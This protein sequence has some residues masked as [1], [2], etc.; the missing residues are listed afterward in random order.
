MSIEMTDAGT[1][2]DRA[3]EL[4]ATAVDFELTPDE[5][6]WLASHLEQCS[7][8]RRATQAYR[9]DARSVERLPDVSAPRRVADRVAHA[10]RQGSPPRAHLPRAVAL[11]GTAVAAI[12]IVAFAALQL[13]SG[14]RVAGPGGSLGP[15]PEASPTPAAAE[16]SNPGS[17][18]PSV[19]PSLPPSLEP[20]SSTPAAV[21]V[22]W[23]PAT[24][25]ADDD[26]T[27]IRGTTVGQG[28]ALAAL[29]DRAGRP[30]LWT[31]DDARSW[32]RVALQDDAFGGLPPFLIAP[33][34]DGFAA[35]GWADAARDT[36]ARRIWLSSNGVDWLPDAEPSGMLGKFGHGLLAGSE[37]LLLAGGRTRSGETVLSASADGT[38]WDRRDVGDAFRGAIVDDLVFQASAFYAVGSVDRAGAIWRSQDGAIWTRLARPPGSAV[39]AGLV[40]TSGGLVA[41]GSTVSSQDVANSAWWSAD[42]QSW[43]PVTMPPLPT[44]EDDR[45]VRIVPAGS[46]LLAAWQ[47]GPASGVRAATSNDGRSWRFVDVEGLPDGVVIEAMTFIDSRIVGLGRDSRG[48]VV[49]YSAEP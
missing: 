9:S 41:Y 18:P 2:H 7:Q 26:A 37:D 32:E 36:S 5:R 1:D 19:P 39:I 44:S 13:D 49:A 47:A 24:L 10:A 35:L 40:E 4:A 17:T 25:P 30:V 42:G 27:E 22:R 11:L 38:H 43:A 23:T 31:S 14:V 46:G 20:S 45:I 29:A 33:F 12:A 21:R 8:C 34:A 15:S 3:E 16:P 48:R 6:A 28:I